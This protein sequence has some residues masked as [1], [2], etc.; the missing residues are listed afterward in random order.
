MT[1]GWLAQ[2]L[3]EEG[4]GGV[5]VTVLRE[6]ELGDE[7]LPGLGEHPLLS[8]REALLF[9]PLMQAANDVGHLVD[10][11]GTQFLDVRLEAARPVRRVGGGLVLLEH[12]EDF[13]D[14]FSGG[15]DPETD[16]VG[17]VHRDHQSELAV[18]QFEDEVFTLLAEHLFVLETFDDRRTMMWVNHLVTDTK[19]HWMNLP[20]MR[21]V[22]CMNAPY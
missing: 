7:D 1:E 8:G 20:V 22:A 6:R 12:L 18:G 11:T 16:L 13:G 21:T 15:N 5:L 19:T 3:V 9:V 2:D 10:V 14:L 4:F 17:R